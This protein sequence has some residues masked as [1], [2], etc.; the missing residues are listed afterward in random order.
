MAKKPTKKK[1]AKK[2]MKT[3]TL[4]ILAEDI[5]TTD[6]TNSSNCA[7]TRALRRAGIWAEEGGGSIYHNDRSLEKRY[8]DTPEDLHE[9]VKRMYAHV[10]KEMGKQSY[11]GKGCEQLG[12]LE[13]ADFDYELEVPDN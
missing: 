11:W 3:I 6:Y 9:K 12:P 4:N 7:I 5:R 13:P 10:E 1:A 2:V 8:I